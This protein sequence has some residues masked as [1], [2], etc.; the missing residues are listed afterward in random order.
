MT[1]YTVQE[2]MIAWSENINENK[3][4][5]EDNGPIISYVDHQ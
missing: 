5:K 2:L 3:A 1:N 4:G